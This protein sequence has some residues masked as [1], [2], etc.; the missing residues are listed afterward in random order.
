MLTIIAKIL[1][2]LN[3]EQSPA[4]LALAI[5]LAMI[6]GFT[7]LL[8]LHN[9]FIVFLVLFFRVNLGIFIISYPIWAMLGWLLSPLFNEVGTWLLNAESMHVMWQSF[10]NTLPGR[11]SNFYFT[12]VTG[13]I[14]IS[15][16]LG[17]ILYPILVWMIQ[18]Y[19]QQVY[20]KIKSSK[21]MVAF[22]ATHFWK[23]YEK[24]SG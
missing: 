24:I 20:H 7:P 4:Q 2:A 1:K 3:S 10:F 8:S 9:L 11:W 15:L 17:I 22:K 6:V 19:R 18:Q 13:G 16:I 14:A 23:I 21:W 12:G 5:I